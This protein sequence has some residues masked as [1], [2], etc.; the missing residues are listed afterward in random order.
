MTTAEIIYVTLLMC[1]L[2]L[3]GLYLYLLDCTSVIDDLKDWFRWVFF[4]YTKEE[5]QEIIKNN[6]ERK[7]EEK[8]KQDKYN[9]EYK[10]IQSLISKIKNDNDLSHFK[11]IEYDHYSYC[12]KID[13]ELAGCG[14]AGGEMDGYSYCVLKIDGVKIKSQW[15][16][17]I[18]KYCK[19]KLDSIETQKIK[20]IIETI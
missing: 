4:Y 7:N 5:K 9:E 20:N 12:D 1:A 11:K 13:I 19:S 14:G 3:F 16:S 17:D 6:Q 2:P 18:Y 8:L 15:S 10:M